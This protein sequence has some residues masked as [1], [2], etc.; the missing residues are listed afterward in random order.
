VGGKKRPDV[1]LTAGESLGLTGHILKIE[2][3]AISIQVLGAEKETPYKIVLLFGS[4]CKG[5]I[6]LSKAFS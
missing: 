1:S 2:T 5:E 6:I 4:S 3:Q